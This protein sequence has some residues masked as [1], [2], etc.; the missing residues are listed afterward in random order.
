MTDNALDRITSAKDIL[1][2]SMW[3]I[4]KKCLI[5][6]FNFP[7]FFF[8]FQPNLYWGNNKLTK[9]SSFFGKES[10]KDELRLFHLFNKKD[11]FSPL[12]KLK[13]VSA[14]HKLLKIF[15]RYPFCLIYNLKIWSRFHF[16][17][18]HFNLTEFEVLSVILNFLSKSLP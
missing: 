17:F 18:N 2:F 14:F 5:P 8:S 13:I 12:R 16:P 9:I 15:F 11:P 3:R 10:N 7:F 4:K 6:Y 1:L